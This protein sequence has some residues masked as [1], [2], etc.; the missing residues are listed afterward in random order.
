MQ[1]LYAYCANKAL[2]SR[3]RIFLKTHIFFTQIDLLSTR[4][5]WIGL[6]K[7]LSK[8]FK[9]PGKNI[10][11]NFFRVK[12]VRFSLSDDRDFE[13]N[14]PAVPKISDDFPKT[15]ERSRNC[16]E[17][18]RRLLRT[19]KAISEDDNFSMFWFD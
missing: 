15:S 9:Y 11:A 13:K 7:P 3:I 10:P 14:V 8:V 16:P 1:Q 6:S 19:S 17:M 4:N 2:S 18:F 12:C 5:Q